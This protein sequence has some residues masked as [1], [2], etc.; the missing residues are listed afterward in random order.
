ML[1][2]AATVAARNATLELFAGV[3]QPADRAGTRS[4]RAADPVLRAAM[5]RYIDRH[6]TGPAITPAGIARAHGVS[7]RTVHRVFSA[8]GTTLGGVV[9]NRRLVRARHDLVTGG[10]P[11]VA[12]AH[13]WG[14]FD[15]S[16]FHRAFTARYGLS[17]GGYRAS[18]GGTRT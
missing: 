6:L 7:E 16:H 4:G 5:E 1:G 9:R 8:D 12:I 3:V 18:L 14:F 15:S 13:R 17:P 10:E 11:I 2:P